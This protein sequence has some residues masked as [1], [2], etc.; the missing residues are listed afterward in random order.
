MRL[1]FVDPNNI[2]FTNSQPKL[3]KLLDSLGI[4]SHVC[5]IRHGAFWEAG[6]HCLT[7]DIKRKGENRRIVEL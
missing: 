3:F 4:N 6:I 7:L 1:S 2:I 5:P